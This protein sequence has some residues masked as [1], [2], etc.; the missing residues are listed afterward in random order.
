[1]YTPLRVHG[2]HS[3]LTGI[4]SPAELLLRASKLGIGAMALADVDT[5]AG[6]V[7]WIEAAEEL[8]KKHPERAVRAILAAEISPA[9]EQEASG[10]LR[11][12][13]RMKRAAPGRLIALVCNLRGYQNLNKL[14]S[15]RQL[16]DDPGDAAAALKG[17]QFFDRVECAIRFQEGLI[18]VVDHPQL[19]LA[20]AGKVPSEQLLIGITP[21]A[22][23]QQKYVRKQ[24]LKG[25]RNIYRSAAPP[26]ASAMRDSTE[27]SDFDAQA[28]RKIPPPP[29]AVPVHDLIGVARATGLATL[30]VPD[31]YYALSS[32]AH[33]HRVRTA[34]KHNALLTDLPEDWLAQTPAHLLSPA[35]VAA[36]Y[37]ELPEV[38]GPFDSAH[39]PSQPGC[40]ER[41]LM[42]AE[43][44]QYLPELGGVVFPDIALKPGDTTY[45]R[46][47]TLS[48]DGARERYRPLRPEVVRRLDYELS[49]IDELGY[50]AYFLLVRQIRDFATSQKIPCVGRGSAADSLVA[51]CLGLTDADPLRYQLPFERFLNPSRKDRPDIDLDFCWR[52]RDE[53]LEHVYD[54]FG[55]ERTAMI[56]TLNRFGLRSAFR[57]AALVEGIPPVEVN[58]WSRQLPWAESN[59]AS[60]DGESA[61]PQSE[62]AEDCTSGSVTPATFNNLPRA[63]REN[64]IAQAFLSVPESRDFPFHDE[65]YTRVLTAAARLVNTPRHFGL[66]PGGVVAT[67]GPITDWVACQRAA[68]GMIVTQHDKNG[69]EALGLVKMDLLGNRALTVLDDC[70]NMLSESGIKAPDL[71]AIDEDEARTAELLRGGH[72]LGCFQV[73]S[74]GMRNL[75]KQTGAHT[76]D[77]VIQAVALIRP[78]PAGSGMKEAYVRRFRKLEEPVAPH[79]C[80]DDVLQDTYGVMLYQE[81]VMR[82]V[83]TMA[84]FSLAEADQIRR[85]L[86]KRKSDELRPLAQR[87]AQ[88]CAQNGIDAADAQRVWVLIAG[89]ASF[90]FCK[91]H[92]VTYGRIA[93][94]AVYLKA[95]YPAAYLTAFLNSQTGYY[96]TRVYTEEARRLGIAIL[97]PDI[98]R[99]AR[100]FKLE[101]GSLRVGLDRVRGLTE[102]TLKRILAERQLAPFLS[103]P[104]F[105]ERSGARTDETEHLIQ[106]GAFDSFDRT[107]PELA[108][109]LHLLRT[110]ERRVPGK[111]QSAGASELDRAQLAACR[112]TQ[113]TR[114]Q[115]NVRRAQQGTGSWGS[116]SRGLGLGAAKLQPGET[117]SLFPE[118]ETPALV[119]PGLP[120]M[121]A[122][123]RGQIELGLLGLTITKH[124]VELYPCE[125]LERFEE[126]VQRLAARGRPKLIGC[127]QLDVSAGQSI[128]LIGWLAATRRVRTNNGKWMRFLTLE[129]RTGIAEVVLFPEVYANFGHLL[130]SKGP[131]C[132]SGTVEEQM[133]ACT[134]HAERIW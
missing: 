3:L 6:H 34:V 28:A 15:A 19:A 84:G 79:A 5:T 56:S 59:A 68:K 36:L 58:R 124:P 24:R 8:A 20:L 73:E 72:T 101:S 134:L 96:Q 35:E 102:N 126:H 78:G 43:R 22:F 7:E 95:H 18:F 53:I 9:P 30:A 50:A 25:S 11:N 115:D 48:F 110:P 83:S 31:I 128:A 91:A 100:E 44:C 87:F 76:M 54:A 80:L 38:S 71:F 16:G 26:R 63:L 33:D 81:D 85:A 17:P 114:K 29:R 90:A 104:D 67:P 4:N 65:R 97:A 120:D 108:W 12:G 61:Q 77:D 45:S 103:L 37:S 82:V 86:S 75:L 119:L 130:I 125:G 133:G 117:P 70:L 131:F 40:V 46:L 116:H 94:R 105:L 21:A 121:D 49:V 109:R 57:E 118:P 27:A 55:S 10:R 113:S 69:V 92:A 60:F 112:A 74:P 98:N 23:V 123:A 129:D 107:R 1:M 93:Y 41:T 39:N 51:Y 111:N 88:G 122:N 106:A 42:I 89:F 13:I 132:I 127:G 62:E 64:S 2:Y 99:S 47:L 66:H 32:S 14:V 52:R